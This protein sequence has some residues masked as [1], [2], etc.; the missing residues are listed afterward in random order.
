MLN[1]FIK[2]GD[3]IIKSIPSFFGVENMLN[4][5]LYNFGFEITK[6]KNVDENQNLDYNGCKDFND[7]IYD[8]KNISTGLNELSGII[9]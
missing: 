5:A 1:T 7:I 4:M 2:K 9:K 8:L 6:L 3:I